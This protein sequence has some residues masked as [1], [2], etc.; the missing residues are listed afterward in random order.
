MKKFFAIVKELC[1]LY[2][3]FLAGGLAEHFMLTPILNHPL[4]SVYDVNYGLGIGAII[5]VIIF[6][7]IVKIDE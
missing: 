6:I 3:S 4:Y 2:W 7:V 5:T 1:F